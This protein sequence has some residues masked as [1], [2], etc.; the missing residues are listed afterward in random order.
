MTNCIISGNARGGVIDCGGQFTNCTISD[1]GQPG[2]RLSGGQFTNCTISGNRIAGVVAIAA[3]G[4]FTNCTITGNARGVGCYHFA[5][6][7]FTN[8]TI[9]GNSVDPGMG[10]GGAISC[11]WSAAPVFTNCTIS[12]NSADQGGAITCTSAAP[13]F[14]NCTISGNSADQGGGLFCSQGAS[15]TLTN[16]VLHDN[17]NHAIYE[18]DA[19][20]DP[21]VRNCLFH[22]N[23]QG[24]YWDENT[25]SL[26]GDG[27]I[28]AAPDGNATGNVAGDPGF[29][30]DGPAEITGIWS[31]VPV[32]VSTTGRT[33]LTDSDAEF[34]TGGLVA[35]LINADTSQRMHAPVMANTAT[36]IEVAGDV[37]DYATTGDSYKLIDF[38]LQNGSAALDCGTAVDAPATDFEGDTRP[39]TDGL[40]DIGVDEALANYAP[41]TPWVNDPPSFTKGPDQ[42]TVED[43]GGQL[44][45]HW[46]VGISDG[47]LEVEQ[48]LTFAVTSDNNGLFAVQPAISASGDLT[49]TPAPDANGAATASVTLT[50]DETASG[51]ALTTAPE[52]FTITATPVNDA[53]TVANPIPD[54]DATEDTE[55]SFTFAANTFNDV[56]AGD[57]LTYTV[58]LAGEPGALP[59]WLNFDVGTRTFWGT[60]RNAD[61]GV[62]SVEVTARDTGNAS[63]TDTFQITVANTNDAP[64]FTSVPVTS[65]TEDSLYTYSITTTDL[66]ADDPDTDLVITGS[67]K[68]TWLTLTDHGDG[69]ATL[70][71]MPLEDHVS[72]HS[73]TLRVTDDHGAFGEQS[74]TL[75]VKACIQT[76]L[77][78]HWNLLSLPFDTGTQETPETVLTDTQGSVLF[79][80]RVWTWNSG[81][82]SYEVLEESFSAE[83]GFWAYCP[84]QEQVMGR[85][86]SGQPSDGSI[87]LE[88]GWNMVGPSRSCLKFDISGSENIDGTI[89]YWD[90]DLQVYRPLKDEEIFERGKGFWIHVP[91]GGGCVIDTGR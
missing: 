9:S 10:R 43:A 60:P 15:P 40:Y 53:P 35:W 14:T 13:I 24:D 72:A 44:N 90:A 51:P 8:C 46:A 21:I 12:G 6:P 88:Q 68:P 30:A 71:G 52:T 11:G 28:N 64:T 5:A 23:P 69:T 48:T 70:E 7:V 81:T 29:A 32:Y 39:G 20:S 18:M 84:A 45:Q 37:T 22:A 87:A 79:V 1:N 75:P 54:Q 19:T 50:D 82:K 56:D 27:Q 58:E 41:D 76:T 55:F 66:D 86:I 74:F 34:P 47:E 65:A 17:T 36:M 63:V 26:T 61:V 33:V 4:Q 85:R 89:W 62:I 3:G 57:T 80:G 2:V 78:P 83:Q 25:T 31:Q 73:V 91:Q 67:A 42:T 49:Y 38:H 16:C 59:D 77:H